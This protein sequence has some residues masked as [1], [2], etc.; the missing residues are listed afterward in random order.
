MSLVINLET[1]KDVLLIRLKGELDHHTA[2]NLR[3][4]VSDEIEK[5]NIHHIVLNLE[6]LAFMDSSGLG[7][8]LGRYKQIQSQGGEMVVCS[9]SPAVKRLFDMSGLFKI[10]R[11]VDDEQYALKTL[12]VA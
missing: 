5:N 6:E 12:G 11:L 7:V 10:I 1:K 2:E 3:N 9:I 4:K 8:I